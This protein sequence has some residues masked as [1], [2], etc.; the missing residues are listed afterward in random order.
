MQ[1]VR[2]EITKEQYEKAR[3]KKGKDLHDY[4]KAG[5]YSLEAL[6]NFTQLFAQDSDYYRDDLA[7]VQHNLGNLYY[8]LHDYIKAEEYYLK[9]LEIQEKKLNLV[10]AIYYM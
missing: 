1:T 3:E 10:G 9:A 2:R 7:M 4:A 5:E 8:S 6:E